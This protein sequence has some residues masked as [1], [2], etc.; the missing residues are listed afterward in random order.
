MQDCDIKIDGV[1]R[2]ELEIHCPGDI[3]NCHAVWIDPLV[4]GKSERHGSVKVPSPKTD[5]PQEP[6]AQPDTRT[7]QGK[8]VNLLKLIRLDKDSLQGKWAFQGD[9]LISPKDEM[10]QL[11]IPYIPPEE[12]EIRVRAERKQ[13]NN[14]LSLR[15]N[16]ANRH[17]LACVDG[18]PHLGFLSG[19][20]MVA[21]SHKGQLLQSGKPSDLIYS[22][23][24]TGVTITVD[25]KRIT[26]YSGKVTHPIRKG[27]VLGNKEAL[28]LG[29]GDVAG[30][31]RLNGSQFHITKME[32]TP[33]SG[34]GRTIGDR[35]NQGQ[36]PEVDP[37]PDIRTVQGKPVNL[38]KLIRLDKDTVTG[39]WAFQKDTLIS[40]E[41]GRISKLQVPYIPPEEYEIRMIAERK[42]G[43]RGLSLG[44]I[45]A[46]Q[47]TAVFLDQYAPDL[48]T[49]HNTTIT[50]GWRALQRSTRENCFSVTSPAKSFARA[51]EGVTVAQTGRR[52]CL[53]KAR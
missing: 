25:D 23:R 36:V 20:D 30:H 44:I 51:E 26:S 48:L 49:I 45:L 4:L 22:V 15:L 41:N 5:Q 37:K 42:D 28:I 27:W 52:S 35:G 40:P 33:I 1:D 16:I 29:T 8:P 43:R 39:K 14:S 19:L 21:T 32:L 17:C 38:L 11:Q 13:G 9:T 10:G 18:Y 50:T 6:T 7:A 53:G 46:N 24:K 2:L 3:R 34:E 31:K 47:Q 12:F